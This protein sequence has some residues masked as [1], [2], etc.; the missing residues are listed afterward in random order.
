LPRSGPAQKQA[1][2]NQAA[3]MHSPRNAPRRSQEFARAQSGAS[4][5]SAL[6]ENSEVTAPLLP[7]PSADAEAAGRAQ[8]VVEDSEPEDED[9]S[10]FGEV[11]RCVP[12]ACHKACFGIVF[13]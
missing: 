13:M 10:W 2:G 3:G 11:K 7:Q 12:C 6:P 1:C 4:S 5:L 8:W 9:L